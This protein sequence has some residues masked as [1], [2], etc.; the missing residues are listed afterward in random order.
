[1]SRTARETEAGSGKCPLGSRHHRNLDGGVGG[2]AA[3]GS[4]DRALDGEDG[5]VLC[6]CGRGRHQ[7]PRDHA[8]QGPPGGGGVG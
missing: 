3:R 1:M 4:G 8:E 5:S 2:G 7:P 6:P